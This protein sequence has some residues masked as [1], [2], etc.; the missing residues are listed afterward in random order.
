VIADPEMLEK[1]GMMTDLKQIEKK[2][3]SCK[4]W[5]TKHDQD[6]RRRI[7]GFA[8]FTKKQK[9]FP[10]GAGFKPDVKKQL[11]ILLIQ[12]LFFLAYLML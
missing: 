5:M 10:A 2:K 3:K 1:V 12:F 4:K 9:M 7:S 8:L 6:Y 11:V